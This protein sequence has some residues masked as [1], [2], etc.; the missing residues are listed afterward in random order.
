MLVMLQWIR[1]WLDFFRATSALLCI[2]NMYMMVDLRMTKS[3][4]CK[5]L[6]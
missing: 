3:T 4:F 6:M 2:L 5:F 1:V